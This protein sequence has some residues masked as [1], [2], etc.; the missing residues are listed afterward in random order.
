MSLMVK[1]EDVREEVLNLLGAN[2]THDFAPPKLVTPALDRHTRNL[3]DLARN[4]HLETA[5]G[6]DAE[7]EHLL[8]V[9]ACADWNVPVL[10]CEGG[11]PLS[12]VTALAPRVAAGTLPTPWRDVAVLALDVQGLVADSRTLSDF[13]DKLYTLLAELRSDKRVVLFVGEIEPH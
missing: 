4:N 5:P 10:V 3:T 2:L 7:A 11:D 8:Q 6:R 1:L 13:S 12:V 9:L